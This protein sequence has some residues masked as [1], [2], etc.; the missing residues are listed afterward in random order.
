MQLRKVGDHHQDP[1]LLL[2]LYCAESDVQIDD[3]CQLTGFKKGT[4]DLKSL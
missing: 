3:K 4:Q 2:D 1:L